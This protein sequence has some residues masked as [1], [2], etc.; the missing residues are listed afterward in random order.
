MLPRWTYRE[1]LLYSTVHLNSTTQCL[2]C[3]VHLDNIHIHQYC[4]LLAKANSRN[5]WIHQ[6]IFWHCYSM[7][8]RR[9]TKWTSIRIQ[10][11]C[12]IERAREHWD[13]CNVHW[14]ALFWSHYKWRGT[15]ANV[16]V[17]IAFRLVN[18]MHHLF[19]TS[20][21]L[22][23]ITMFYFVSRR[24]ACYN[25]AHS[26]LPIFCHIENLMKIGRWQ[27]HYL[28]RCGTELNSLT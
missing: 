6:H 1:A 16:I 4:F 14:I 17:I 24:G 10:A 7:R 15:W 8:P 25:S 2:D 5:G 3:R 18:T 26:L 28:Y 12:E 19:L 23:Y 13:R 9:D 21:A 11:A 20:R 27:I 22:V